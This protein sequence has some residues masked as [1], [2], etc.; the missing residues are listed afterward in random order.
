MY[1]GHVILVWIQLSLHP[2]E[3]AEH[4]SLPRSP[5]VLLPSDPDHRFRLH[6]LNSLP[7]GVLQ[8]WT[9]RIWF[10]THFHRSLL[11][12]F[13]SHSRPQTL[14]ERP[15]GQMRSLLPLPFLSPLPAPFRPQRAP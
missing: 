15:P 12:N 9:P 7:F 13:S 10:R 8:P 1:S 6:H 4:E 2:H 14:H 5:P 3:R 11:P